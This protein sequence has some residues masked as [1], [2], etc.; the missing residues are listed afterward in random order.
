MKLKLDDLKVKYIEEQASGWAREWVLDLIHKYAPE[1]ESGSFGEWLKKRGTE[2]TE[3][4]RSCPH[5]S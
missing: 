2:C 3:R 1:I 4:S 5:D